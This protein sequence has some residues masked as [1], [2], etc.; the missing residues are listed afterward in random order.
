MY[1]AINELGCFVASRTK[2][3]FPETGLDRKQQQYNKDVE[4][5]KGVQGLTEDDKKLHDM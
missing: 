3:S 5:D 1:R 4:G 2:R